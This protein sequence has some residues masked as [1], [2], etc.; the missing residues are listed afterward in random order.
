MEGGVNVL[1][2]GW[3]RDI[4][5]FTGVVAFQSFSFAYNLKLS[6]CSHDIA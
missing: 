6:V 2:L 5:H 1:E 4:V 3:S